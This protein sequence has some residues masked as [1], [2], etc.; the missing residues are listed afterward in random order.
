MEPKP[1]KA[2]NATELSERFQIEDIEW[3]LRQKASEGLS[4]EVQQRYRELTGKCRNESL[5]EAEHE[6][7]LRLTDISERKQAERLEALVELARL[8]NTSLRELMNALGI[9]P[10]PVE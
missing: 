5:T 3:A 2:M 10:P 8:R 6:E 7:L 1:A 4:T 9:K